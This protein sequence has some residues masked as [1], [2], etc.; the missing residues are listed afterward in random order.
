MDSR[1]MEYLSEI[2]SLSDKATPGPWFQC[3]ACV[4]GEDD[5]FVAELVSE[6]LPDSHVPV[7]I[8]ANGKFIAHSRTSLPQLAKALQIFVGHAEAHL[9]GCFDM[10]YADC[11]M[12]LT[13]LRAISALLGL[14]E[15][16][17]EK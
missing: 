13:E 3:L 15:R 9:K 16:K 17:E 12:F 1:L 8:N 7:K 2:L 5:V 6:Q 10:R 14:A 4:I 11:K